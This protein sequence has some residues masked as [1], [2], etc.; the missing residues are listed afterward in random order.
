ML[1]RSGRTALE[2]RRSWWS[3][4]PGI[5]DDAALLRAFSCLEPFPSVVL[6]VS[7]GPDS[8]ALMHLARRWARL[9]ERSTAGFAV[10]TIDHKL[11]AESKDEA[12]FV[13]ERARA[14]GFSHTTI[15]W[16]GEKPKTGLQAAARKA[17]YDLLSEYCAARDIGCIVTAHTEDD[18]AE[19]FLMRLRRGSG[20]D[21]LAAMATLSNRAGVTVARPLLRFS[22][23]RL[24]AYLRASS[25]PF[26]QDPSNENT[27]FERVRIRYAM[28]ALASAGVTRP[29]LA[30]AATR[31]GRSREA[32]I[33]ITDDFLDRHFQ[34]THLAQGQ[35]GL[36][37]FDALPGDIA[38][39]ALARVLALIGGQQEAP[40]LI[41][42]ERLLASLKAGKM[43]A[44]LG[45]CIVISAAGKLNFYREPGRM[46]A[47]L[48]E[49]EPGA[50]C[51]WDGRFL[52]T[53][54]AEGERGTMVRQLGADGWL[55][56]RKVMKQRR[57]GGEANR[58]AALT[59]PALWKGNFLICAPML[60]FFHNRPGV[61]GEAAPQPIKAALAPSLTRFFIHV[62][63][64]AASALGKD[65][66]IPYL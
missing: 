13:A 27:A 45:G 3:A 4:V 64:E 43:E 24:A 22:K 54:A 65:T 61:P 60:G 21:G 36:E 34:V 62:S 31:L 38:L 10:V 59:T 17:R 55:L 51:V 11:R 19:T 57:L 20:L 40:R 18:Q 7:G 12:A 8:M 15:E 33:R 1:K 50:S 37:A 9:A 66:P 25:I 63:T 35:I 26:V 46:K 39:R 42:A 49:F 28:R 30:M 32:L 56:Y 52:I 23:T 48:L 14:L 29:S 2:V 16:T 41:R 44:T 6:A 58:L 5:V 53:F 47:P